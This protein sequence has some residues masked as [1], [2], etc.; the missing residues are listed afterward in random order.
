MT[1]GAASLSQFLSCSVLEASGIK[2]KAIYLFAC[3]VGPRR[4]NCVRVFAER[5]T[6]SER[7]KWYGSFRGAYTRRGS[8]PGLAACRA[9]FPTRCPITQYFFNVQMKENIADRYDN[10]TAEGCSVIVFRGSVF[11]LFLQCLPDKVAE[12]QTV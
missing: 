12:R 2:T 8:E 9:S 5:E 10:L 7:K 4:L 11:P 6:V 1:L 3:S